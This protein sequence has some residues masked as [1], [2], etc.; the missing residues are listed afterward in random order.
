M[1]DTFRIPKDV[2]AEETFRI[3]IRSETTRCEQEP[4]QICSKARIFIDDE[5]H[6]N[7]RKRSAL[8]HAGRPQGD[9]V[10]LWRA[11]LLGIT[12]TSQDLC[13]FQGF[14]ASQ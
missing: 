4:H 11:V 1:E 12:R 8:S 13:R 5:T 6:V 2:C 3:F 7:K 9:Q 10:Q 14:G